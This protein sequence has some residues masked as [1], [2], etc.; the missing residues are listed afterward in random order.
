MKRKGVG[1]SHAID[2]ISEQNWGLIN[3]VNCVIKSPPFYAF[4]MYLVQI[5]LYTMYLHL[6]VMDAI[7]P[8][9]SV[10]QQVNYAFLYANMH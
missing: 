8:F 5:C 7:L 9:L 2:Y 10:L 6:Q 3:C 1:S 4:L